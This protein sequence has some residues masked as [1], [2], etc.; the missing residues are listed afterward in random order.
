MTPNQWALGIGGPGVLK[1]PAMEAALSPMKRLAELATEAHQGED[2][3]Y[4]RAVKLAKLK[5][6]EGEKA[7]RKALSNSPGADVS[8]YLETEEPEAPSCGA[9][10]PTTPLRRPWVSYT[11]RTRTACWC[12]GMRWCPY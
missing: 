12:S 9:I 6:E 1:S 2:A 5:A 3:E 4:R 8:G 7:A 11:D 10:S